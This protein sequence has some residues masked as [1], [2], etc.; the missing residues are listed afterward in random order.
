MRFWLFELRKCSGMTQAQIANATGIS[1]P[2]Y[3]RIETGKSTPRPATAKRIASVLGFDWTRF[4][5][6]AGAVPQCKA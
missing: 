6:D 2:S 3:C 1:K 5:Q 4:Y